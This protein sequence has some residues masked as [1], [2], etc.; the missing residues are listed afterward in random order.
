M[1]FLPITKQLIYLQSQRLE[2]FHK[3][4]MV[5]ILCI[6]FGARRYMQSYQCIF[7]G[8]VVKKQQ[9]LVHLNVCMLVV[10]HRLISLYL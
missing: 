8:F 5:N 1:F 9:T 6:M 7:F 4:V 3:N 2:K 10:A